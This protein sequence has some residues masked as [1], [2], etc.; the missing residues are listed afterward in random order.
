MWWSAYGF[1]G[2]EVERMYSFSG[3]R[4]GAHMGF[5]GDGVER[6]KLYCGLFRR[7]DGAHMGF[8]ERV[9][10]ILN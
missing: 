1:A 3:D 5:S 8:S 2:D 7:R 4:G 9:D 10:T 6:I